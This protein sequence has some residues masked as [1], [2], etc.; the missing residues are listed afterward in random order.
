M[1]MG[2][3]L[4]VAVVSAAVCSMSAVQSSGQDNAPPAAAAPAAAP[5]DSSA[6]AIDAAHLEKAN[7][8]IAKGIEYLM[9]QRDEDGCWSVNKGAMKAAITAMVLKALVQNPKYGAQNEAVKKGFEAML[10]FK[11]SD[12]GIYDPKEGKGGYST[13]VV[14]MAIAA[15]KDPKYAGDIKD[16]IAYLKSLQIV[17]GAESADS[18]KVKEDDPRVGGVSYGKGPGRPDLSNVGMWMDA[19]H[20][21]GVK[22]DDPAFQNAAAYI[23]R[24]QNNTETN[25][26]AWAE[27]GDNDGGFIYTFPTSAPA[28]GPPIPAD[29][30]AQMVRSYGSMTY[31]GF[32]SLL[33]AGVERKDPRVMAAFKWIRQF[34]QLDANP[35]MPG[36]Q[37]KS[38]IF[39]YYHV[40]AKALR[41]WGE[42]VITDLKGVKHNWRNE[43]VDCLAGLQ[44]KN[45]SWENKADRWWE[46]Y[47]VLTTCYA[48][49]ALQEA[50]KKTPE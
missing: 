25:K 16:A 9:T 26:M 39:Y 34:W 6:D 30:A 44:E 43:L 29:R 50:T 23:S 31:T 27:K 38:G 48:V 40:F 4:L 24:L 8:S 17:P 46:G 15:A 47:P 12:G 42:P 5:A 2:R 20:E 1:N 28:G 7:A 33:Y 45:G 22:N 3:L 10:K 36:A 19:L 32:K 18:D 35:N 41:A 13:A 14:L 49:L 21:A 11:Q 37:S